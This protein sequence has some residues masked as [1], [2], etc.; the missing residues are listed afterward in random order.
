ML[1][2]LEQLSV[3]GAAGSEIPLLVGPVVLPLL[4]AGGWF[5][6]A[7]PSRERHWVR[8]EAIPQMLA[9]SE[10]GEK[11]KTYVLARRVD[12]IP[13]E[14]S[15]YNV[16]RS[17]FVRPV[18]IRTV[19]QAPVFRKDYGAPDSSWIPLGR[20]PLDQ[21]SCR[22]AAGGAVGTTDRLRIRLRLPDSGAGRRP[23]RFTHPA[24]PGEGA[25]AGDGSGGRRPSRGTPSSASGTN[26]LRVG[27]YLMDRFEVTNRDFKRFVDDGGYRRKELWEHPFML[28]ARA[29]VGGGD[30]AHDGPHRTAGT[31]HLG[32]G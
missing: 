9:L 15:L 29:H 24:R 8:E 1:S 10:A 4:I 26:D 27:D 5:G 14:D 3:S 16:L 32:G 13:P 25:P 12:E 31:I 23:L 7:R 17:R 2:R 30:G 20:T 18:N 22:C 11:E 19:P 28:A 21:R 6:W